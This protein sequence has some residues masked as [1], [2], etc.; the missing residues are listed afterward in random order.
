MKVL[1]TIRNIRWRMTRQIFYRTFYAKATK[2]MILNL[3]FRFIEIKKFPIHSYYSLIVFNGQSILQVYLLKFKVFSALI[4]RTK[5]LRYV[6]DVHNI[7][8]ISIT[9]NEDLQQVD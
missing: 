4:H 8:L 7:P 5:G 6:F 3:L 9:D 1:V 2:G